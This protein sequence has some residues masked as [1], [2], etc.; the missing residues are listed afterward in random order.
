MSSSDRLLFNR[1]TSVHQA[2]GGGLFADVILWRHTNVTMGIFIVTLASWMMFERSDYTFLSYVSNVL[3]LLLLIL[4]LWA[5]SA[6]ILNRPTPPIPYL[7]LS[8]ETTNEAAALIREQINRVLSVSHD[9]AL[10]K[11]PKMFVKVAA[12]LF[13]ISTI[14]NLTD[15]RTLCYTSVFV[16]LI[17]PVSYERYEEHVDSVL[18]KGNLKLKELY[19]RFDE[20]CVKKVRKWILEKN[21]LS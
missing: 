6:Q 2:L 4:F 11:D 8:E 7:Q 16:A 1:Q 10:G 15:F 13:I 12:Y 3:L 20:E 5:K 17:V 21:K 18:V 9:I 14:G 19:I